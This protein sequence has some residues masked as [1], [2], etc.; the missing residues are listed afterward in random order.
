MGGS[1]L[2]LRCRR[3]KLG[4]LSGAC[5]GRPRRRRE[6]ASRED[7]AVAE[8]QCQVEVH[9]QPLAGGNLTSASPAARNTPRP[10][11][12]PSDLRDLF[13]PERGYLSTS[14]HFI[15]QSHSSQEVGTVKP[16][17]PKETEAQR[18]GG[19]WIR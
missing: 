18:D 9:P 17:S 12:L 19:T 16:V 7:A 3:N 14:P 6:R 5:D 15:L 4:G 13:S 11:Q 1:T 10:L 2:P 8:G